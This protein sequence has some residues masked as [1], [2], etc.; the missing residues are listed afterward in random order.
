MDLDCKRKATTWARCWSDIG[1][2]FDQLK[3][4]SQTASVDHCRPR[5]QVN[6]GH[7][8]PISGLNIDLSTKVG[9][10]G[11]PRDSGSANDNFSH[12]AT[13]LEETLVQQSLQVFSSD[14]LHAVVLFQVKVAS[15]LVKL[16][17]SWRTWAGNNPTAKDLREEGSWQWTGQI[18]VALVK[19][20][21]AALKFLVFCVCQSQVN[22]S[23]VNFRT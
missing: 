17:N 6:Y 11:L 23:V 10:R 16:A 8:T 18:G 7:V 12:L 14:C 15:Y 1:W 22:L 19:E 5:R 13:H 3:N 9:C 21:N 2:I 20:W 4:L